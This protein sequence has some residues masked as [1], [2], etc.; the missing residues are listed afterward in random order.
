MPIFVDAVQI[1]AKEAQDFLTKLRLESSHLL[2]LSSTRNRLQISASVTVCEE[3][4]LQLRARNL[5][6]QYHIV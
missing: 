4:S 2:S 1:L 3:H 6:S 5:D